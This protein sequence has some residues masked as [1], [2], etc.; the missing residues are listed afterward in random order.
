MYNANLALSIPYA[1]KGGTLEE[2]KE[3]LRYKAQLTK[4][5]KEEEELYKT[6]LKNNELLLKSLIKVFK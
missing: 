4:D 2:K 6:I 1:A 3:L 5:Q